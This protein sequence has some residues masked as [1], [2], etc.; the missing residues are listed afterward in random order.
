MIS[1]KYYAFNHDNVNVS[2]DSPGVYLLYQGQELSYIGRASKSIRDRLKAHFAGSEGPCT[3]RA[4]WYRR[5]MH[6][7]PV[8]REKE[9][10]QHFRR[11]F[12]RLPRC[13]DRI[14]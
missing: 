1:S 7:D 14:G 11:E 10:L 9:L 2:P 13:N 5:E 12:A 4:T 8:G 3:S 6:S